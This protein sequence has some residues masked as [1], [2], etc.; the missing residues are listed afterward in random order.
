LSV[1]VGDESSAYREWEAKEVECGLDGRLL[2]EF[3]VEVEVESSDYREWEGK[4]VECG[5]D[6]RFSKLMQEKVEVH[7]HLRVVRMTH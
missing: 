6:G 7:I 4:E 5:L 3:G 1:E 2:T